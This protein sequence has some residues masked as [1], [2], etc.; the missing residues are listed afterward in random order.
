ML[1]LIALANAHLFRMVEFAALLGTWAARRRLLEDP[2]R[3]RNLL[4]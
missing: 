1:L 4:R 2:A 3:H